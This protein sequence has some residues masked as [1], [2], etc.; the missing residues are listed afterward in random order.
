ML[1]LASLE[2]DFPASPMT[3]VEPRKYY[4]AFLKAE[5]VLLSAP[6]PLR[7]SS[8]RRLNELTSHFY[9]GGGEN[10]ALFRKKVD[11]PDALTTLWLSSVREL[12]GWFIAA[13]SIPPFD[14]INQ[15]F[16]FDLPR[17]FKE[18]E[19]LSNVGP[20]LAKHGIALLYEDSIPGIKL[21][22]A[23]FRASS[24]QIV[25]AMSLRYS[26]LDYYWFT[27]LHELAH[28]VLHADKLSSPILDDLEAD[29]EELIEQQADRLASDSLIPRNEW[30]SCPARYTNDPADIEAFAV[31]Q[32]I[33]PQS[34][35]GR[36]RRESGR[37][38]LFSEIVN[39]YDVREVLRGAKE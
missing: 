14:G 19:D 21:D 35:A 20:W 11:A 12:A 9:R 31:K 10:G 38:E 15:E 37:Y 39:K 28:V 23:V 33:T 27:L 4:E 8:E 16:L 25:V 13:N 3:A 22:G 18:V 7:S 26:R 1:I 5:A 30:R 29:S 32:N 24:G 34:V 6:K 2:D 17:Q 36:L